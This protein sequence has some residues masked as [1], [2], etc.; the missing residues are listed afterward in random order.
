M[1]LYLNAKYLLFG[2]TDNKNTTNQ[3][4]QAC[5]QK[6][7]QLAAGKKQI[8]TENSYLKH[9]TDC[10]KVENKDLRE[11]IAKASPN[12]KD[13]AE[14]ALKEYVKLQDQISENN[15]SL[16]TMILIL[17]LEKTGCENQLKLA[18]EKLSKLEAELDSEVDL[19]EMQ[20][21]INK[22]NQQINN[23][24][25]EIQELKL[26]NSNLE[27]TNGDIN[28]AL[29]ELKKVNT[30]LSELELT[31]IESNDFIKK[32][33][34]EKKSYEN[35]IKKLNEKIQELSKNENSDNEEL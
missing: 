17:E 31:I 7:K 9:E 30:T 23:L 5:K 4:C 6:I 15:S 27:M 22:L 2:Y 8:K 1:Y 11:L 35:D 18:L 12:F 34:D 19:N 10:L 13:N 33:Q 32:L 26:K 28:K 24:Q 29:N 25:N 3:G 21:E 14:E 20:E 16:A